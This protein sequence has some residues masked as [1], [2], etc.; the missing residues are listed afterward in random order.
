MTRRE[1]KKLALLL[2]QSTSMDAT[3]A[4]ELTRSLNLAFGEFLWLAIPPSCDGPET[5]WMIGIEN[6]RRRTH[7]QA[8]QKAEAK[9][10]KTDRDGLPLSS[11]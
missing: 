3:F 5:A 11:V 9:G 1:A 10:R 2:N 4:T 6:R 7:E 8:R